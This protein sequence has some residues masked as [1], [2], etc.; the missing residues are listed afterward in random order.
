MRKLTLLL[1]GVTLL[2]AQQTWAQNT[3]TGQ[4]TDA[5]G[6]PIARATIKIKDG[7]GGTTAGNDGTFKIVAPANAILII[8]AVGFENITVPVNNRQVV[9]VSLT[10][11]TSSLN[12]VVVTAYG[13]KR[14]KKALGYAV[15]TVTSKDL[16]LKPE[17]DIARILN[18][19]APGVNVLSTSGLSGSGTNINIRGI[20]TI[21]GGSTPLF[22][23][24]GVAFDG[25]TNAQGN[26]TYGNTTSSRFLDLD[27][28][29]IESISILKGLA[30]ATQY[31]ENGRNGVI[32]VTTKNGSTQK[33]R[34]KSEISVSQSYSIIKAILPE[35]ND[36]YG[37]GFD[38]SSGV[39]FF[40]NWGSAFTNP[41]EIV[42]HPYDKSRL[43]D[44]FPQYKGAPYER[45]YY[46]SVPNFFRSGNNKTTSIN[47]AG[48]TGGNLNYN[49]NYSYTDD[50]GYLENNGLIK[51]S[52]GMGGT[53]KLTNKFT[54][55]GTVNYVITDQKAPPT[56]DS[57]G[58]NASNSSI[59]GN[60]LY[61]PTS[62]DLM[63]LPYESPL[64][65]SQVYYRN[66]NDIQNPRWTLYNA[67]TKDKVHR[68]FG[69]I[70]AGY[71]LTKG[72]SLTYK[73]G[74]D[75]YSEEQEYSQNKGGL[76]TPT[77]LLRTTSGNSTIWNNQLYLNYYGNLGKDF[78]IEAYAGADKTSQQYSQT[79][80]RSQQQLVYGLMNHTNF[81]SHDEYSEDGSE[82]NY[83]KEQISLGVYSFVTVGYRNFAYITAGGRNSWSSTV[84]ERNR[85]IFYPNISASFIPT[86]AFTSLQNSNFLKYLKLR[87][88]YS[89]SASF[90]TPYNTRP[91]LAIA[92][93]VFVSSVGTVVNINS[94]PNRKPNS[95]L[96]PELL[97]EVEAGLESKLWNNR[98][99]VDLTLYQRTSKDQILESPTDPASG[100]TSTFINAGKVTNK[101]I[102]LALGVTVVN[103]K[104]W[105]W[106]VD[107]IYSIN[108]SKVSEIPADLS[109]IL[110][111]GYSNFGTFATNGAPLGVIKASS[112]QKDPKTGQRVV[113]SDGNYI[114]NTTPTIIGD[115]N[116]LYKLSGISTLSYK[117]I[118]FRMQWDYT[119][120]GEMF[121]STAAALLGRGVTKDTKFDRK[122]PWILPGVLENGEPNNIEISSSQVFYGNG[123][124]NGAANE[125]GIFDQTCI[126]LREVS[127]SYS[128]PPS[129]LT[130]LPIG[131]LSIGVSGSNL[132]YY[133][134]NFPKYTHFDP[135][136]SG[137]SVGN[138][139]GMEFL[140]GPSAR[141]FG[142]SI[143]ITF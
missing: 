115:P 114:T 67:F 129:M 3:I 66:S 62:M 64:D 68:I 30:A 22:V 101:G 131:G 70:Q 20:S 139:R 58:N 79:G 78:T 47:A 7:G 52:F 140:S 111:S 60:V 57:Y 16:E 86:T 32:I 85:S 28:N 21:T 11:V 19:K 75:N 141:R 118:S 134:P 15:S 142:A 128:V 49:I 24:D 125:V 73:I 45:K 94:I 93:R 124:P 40:S 65:H 95:N 71:E 56:S 97:G 117:S 6:L 108:K 59:F 63:G 1:L 82:L 50:K 41:P 25:S 4:V 103:L 54:V 69:K 18:G 96:K 12:E 17:N 91:Y 72:L 10:Q 8:S 102:E 26:F 13:I 107:G 37:G 127:I 34:T 105:K 113:G 116:P 110:I 77:G 5:N 143:R 43:N 27:P 83:K 38:E 130:H 119:V 87:V 39:V 74:Y 133:A 122:T 120:G 31:G 46:S 98:I 14:E 123:L 29:N 81:I 104:D 132:W 88:G 100:Y 23:V 9:P 48:T 35:Y 112:F 126:R 42:T 135:E 106:Q 90:P 53:A 138:G 121:S 44:I 109:D 136:S 89:T 137:L 84:E 99:T 51:N 55:S 92:P 61:T 2:F 33:T 76:Y 80:Q 36:G